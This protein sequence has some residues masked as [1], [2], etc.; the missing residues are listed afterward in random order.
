MSGHAPRVQGEDLHRHLAAYRNLRVQLERAMLPLATSLD[1]LTFEFQAPLHDL[2]FRSGGYVVLETSAGPRLGQ[3][4]TLESSTHAT[5]AELAP[6]AETDV[7]LRYARGTGTV[8]ETDGTAF[9]DAAVRPAGADEVGPWLTSRVPAG[10]AGLTI[11]EYALAPGVTATLDS[12][13]LTR[14]T[15]VCGQSGS[16]KTYSLGLLLERVLAETSI[17][18]VVLD[19]NSDYVG[20]GSVLEDADPG[21][22]ARYAH[23]SDEVSVWGDTAAADRRLRLRFAE[24]DPSIQAAVLDLDPIADREEYAELLEQVEARRDGTSPPTAPE[25]LLTADSPRVRQL[26]Q[27][28]A[29]LGVLRW[30][31]WGPTE[32]SLVAALRAHEHRCTIVDLGSL[33][34]VGEQRLVTQAVLA[35][36][37]ELRAQRVPCLLVV[38]E[39]HNILPARP[40]DPLTRL[41][42]ERAVQIAAEGRKYG[43]YLLCSTQQPHKVH[44]NAVSQCDNLVLMRMNSRADIADLV[45]IFSFVPEG[46]LA[47]AT[48]FRMG[49]ALV[50]GRLMP[51]PG[52]VQMGRRITREGGTDVPATW[53]V[54]RSGE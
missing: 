53:A 54:P 16:G 5:A 24:L 49:Q 7:T 46:L 40:E 42:T 23:V 4:V 18:V 20:L 6:G 41:S 27:R 3:V 31:I 35:T 13:G 15:F 45:R 14:H 21:L 32:P 50:A 17:R 9:H 30:R 52:F 1:G 11:G 43:L 22:A 48:G 29:N 36:M 33:A 19:P 47:Q 2:A 37:W 10:R 51:V 34:T 38:D 44:E 39:A 12:G 25:E 8:L 28:A 26:G